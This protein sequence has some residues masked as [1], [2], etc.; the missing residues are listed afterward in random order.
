M[1]KLFLIIIL[2][3]VFSALYGEDK[4]EKMEYLRLFPRIA[5]IGDS[6]SSGEIVIDDD[7]APGVLFGGFHPERGVVDE[8]PSCVDCIK[9]SWLSHIC[10]R[11][12]AAPVH[13]T[14]GGATAQSWLD[15]YNY[16]L[17]LDKEKYPCFF[18]ALGSNDLFSG[19][20]IGKPADTFK[21]KTFCGY[22]N[23][24]IKSVRIT[25][26]HSIILCLSMY[27]REGF[28]NKNGDKYT[29]FSQAIKGI[30]ESHEKC[31]F[32]DFAGTSDNVLEK[33][34]Y[35]RRGHYDSIGYLAISYEIQALA[36]KALAD[37]KED[38][39]EISLYF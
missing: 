3:C 34:S 6:L 10:R 4:G 19:Y 28:V 22:Y 36:E 29:D 31:Y 26:P 1:K 37:H 14:R 5:I 2:I 7:R 18:I 12:N 38:L 8:G 27:N 30:A 17:A 23:E 33:S 15:T 25:N 13:F 35:E 21:E 11:V 32:L 24:I 20:A 39:R 16:F 9:G